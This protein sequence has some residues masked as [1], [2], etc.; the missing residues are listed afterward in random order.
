MTKT[1]IIRWY[2]KIDKHLVS[3]IINT[4]PFA[5]QPNHYLVI[6]VKNIAL[7]A[8]DIFIEI[9][10]FVARISSTSDQ[11][12]CVILDR[13]HHQFKNIRNILLNII[14]DFLLV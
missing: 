11:I 1:Q 14:I 7:F 6:I 2:I 4:N 8:I 10:V 13:L 3:I 9:C 12:F 5:G